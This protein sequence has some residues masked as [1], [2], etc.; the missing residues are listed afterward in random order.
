MQRRPLLQTIMLSAIFYIFL[1][2][3]GRKPQDYDSVH[4][5]YFTSH[6]YS[7][8]RHTCQIQSSGQTVCSLTKLSNEPCVSLCFVALLVLPGCTVLLD[9]QFSCRRSTHSDNDSMMWW[10][11]CT[12]LLVLPKIWSSKQ[13]LRLSQAWDHKEFTFM[14]L[15]RVLKPSF[16]I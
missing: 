4:H 7:D 3:Q 2:K 15:H 11:R 5:F 13:I 12:A 16:I 10:S 9:L 1:I 8:S 6:V 14:S